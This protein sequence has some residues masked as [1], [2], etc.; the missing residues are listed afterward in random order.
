MGGNL[1]LSSNTAFTFSFRYN[2]E[3]IEDL[4]NAYGVGASSGSF[5]SWS[6]ANHLGLLFA[7]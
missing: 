6:L 1:W 5:R 7:F 4:P 2:L 3:A